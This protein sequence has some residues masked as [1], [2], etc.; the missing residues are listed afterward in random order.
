M[1]VSEYG[2]FAVMGVSNMMQYGQEVGNCK[3]RER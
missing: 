1:R 3:E 2:I